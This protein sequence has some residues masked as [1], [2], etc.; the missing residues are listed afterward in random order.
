MYSVYHPILTDP[1]KRTL[2]SLGV[3]IWQIIAQ[4]SPFNI[5]EPVTEGEQAQS[6]LE[7]LTSGKTPYD[8]GERR[9][10]QE[11]A[12]DPIYAGVEEL[13]RS[14]CSQDPKLRPAAKKV[15]NSLLEVIT[16]AKTLL[17]PR[18]T[19]DEEAH[20]R[21]LGLIKKSQRK[22]SSSSKSDM[23]LSRQDTSM[24]RRLANGDPT[25]AYLL[26]TAIW[27]GLVDP[28]DEH[29]GDGQIIVLITG[30]DQ[31]HG[32]HSFAFFRHRT[33]L[34]CSCISTHGSQAMILTQPHAEV[35]YRSAIK[36]LEYALQADIFEAR[37]ALALAYRDLGR[38]YYKEGPKH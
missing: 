10:T 18:P 22:E 37:N 27:E 15:A 30:R 4:V 33:G 9:K 35:K 11:E 2:H 12:E 31:K 8:Y 19:V 34:T 7:Q 6:L 21:I 38:L 32:T 13:V 23:M 5:S 14:C 28:L 3:I 24:L 1:I 20:K 26:G 36:H 25:A 17:D 16:S 29:D